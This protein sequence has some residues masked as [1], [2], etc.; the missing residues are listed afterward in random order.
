MGMRQL[1]LLLSLL[2]YFSSAQ[3]QLQ[4]EQAFVRGLPPGQTVTGAFMQLINTG[5]QPLTLIAAKTPVSERAEIHA[6]RHHN[7]MM[8]MERVEQII[9]PANSSFSLAPG[10]HHLMLIDLKAPLAE[11]QQV[12]VEWQLAN[13]EWLSFT[14]PVRSV[15]NEHK[16]HH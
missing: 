9:V 10:K 14:I 11:G 3:A 13:G 8:S 5:D 4:L 15:L 7:G 6:H 12:P 1:F 2:I 16:S